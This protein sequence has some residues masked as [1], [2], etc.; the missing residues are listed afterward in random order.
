MSTRRTSAPSV[1]FDPDG[2]PVDSE[3]SS[4]PSTTSTAA[5]PVFTAAALLFPGGQSEF[6]VQ[7][8]YDRQAGARPS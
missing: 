5:D 4:L 1:L 6:T 3:G 8:S 2:T 7:A